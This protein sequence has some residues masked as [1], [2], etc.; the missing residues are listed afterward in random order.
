MIDGPYIFERDIMGGLRGGK[1]TFFL[2][3]SA[4]PLLHLFVVYKEGADE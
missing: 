3:V 4:S 1:G 2:N